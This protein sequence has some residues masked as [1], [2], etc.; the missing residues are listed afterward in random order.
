[1]SEHGHVFNGNIAASTPKERMELRR[2][3]E[4]NRARLSSGTALTLDTHHASAHAR[5]RAGIQGRR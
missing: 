4:C 1:M 2:A 5:E 3:L